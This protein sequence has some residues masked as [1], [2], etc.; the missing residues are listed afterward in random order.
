MPVVD[1]KP[2][3]PPEPAPAAVRIAA[4]EYKGTGVDTKYTPAQNVLSMIEGSNWTIDYYSQV[5]GNDSLL[6]GQQVTIDPMVQQYRMLKGMNLKVSTPLASQQNQ[7]TQAMEVRGA[8]NVLP[9]LIPNVGD[10]F[11]GDLGDGRQGRF[12]VTVCE[13]KAFFRDSVYAIE[14]VLIGYSTPETVGDLAMKTIQ[15]LR[16]VEDFMLHGQNPLLFEADYVLLLDLHTSYFKI[17]KRYLQ[18]FV[19]NEY[20][21]LLVPGQTQPIYD[22]FLTKAFMSF[23]STDDDPLIR[24]IR[25]LNTDGDESLK[26]TSIWDALRE[27]DA[28]LLKYCFTRSG[29]TLAKN[30]PRDPMLESIYHSGVTFLVYPLNAERL[31]DFSLNN[32]TKAIDDAK[33]VDVDSPF[34]NDPAP[35]LTG[36]PYGE[37]PLINAV[38]T[39]DFYV[40]SSAFYNNTNPGQSKLELAVRDFLNNQAI[41]KKLLQVLCLDYH[42]WGALERFYYVPILLCLIKAVIRGA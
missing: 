37:A 5:L 19:S 23:F 11:L 38:G 28:D 30:F 27:C 10:M 3:A 2:G 35:S 4:P 31:T 33:L 7:Q 41:N 8:A 18:S 21:T 16:Y 26:A 22:G 13:K 14:Y 17:L 34:E 20:S 25:K 36:L 39:G 9:F 40:F 32:A 15:V 6:A 24:K 12:R 1:I 42:R 29:L